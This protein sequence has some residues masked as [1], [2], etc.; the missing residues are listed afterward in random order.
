MLT[1]MLTVMIVIYD[2]SV[3]L[4]MQLIMTEWFDLNQKTNFGQKMYYDLKE[5]C[6]FWNGRPEVF[7][8]NGVLRNFAKLTGSNCEQ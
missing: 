6:L 3:L 1:V 7:Y 5:Q 8:K 4:M 2:E